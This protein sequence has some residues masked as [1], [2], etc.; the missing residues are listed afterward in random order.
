MMLRGSAPGGM[1]P[2][3]EQFGIEIDGEN[4]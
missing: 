3:R 4:G 2:L 1:L